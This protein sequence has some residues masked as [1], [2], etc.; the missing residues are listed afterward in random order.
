[1]FPNIWVNATLLATS[2][3]ATLGAVTKLFDIAD[4]GLS[5]PVK[6]SIAEIAVVRPVGEVTARV[7]N[8]FAHAF[9]A[10]F[11]AEHFTVKC[12]TR[13]AMASYVVTGLASL[14]WLVRPETR[15]QLSHAPAADVASVLLIAPLAVN[16]LPDYVSLVKTR[17][18][19][20]WLNEASSAKRW[21]AAMLLDVILSLAIALTSIAFWESQLIAERNCESF[22]AA[23]AVLGGACSQADFMTFWRRGF[24]ESLVSLVAALPMM[25]KLHPLSAPGFSAGIWLY[26]A[27]M[28]TLWLLLFATA[29]WVVRMGW[30]VEWA[31]RV[32]RKW[33]IIETRPLGG[34][35]LVASV[36]ITI[37]YALLAAAWII[38]SL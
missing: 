23:T 3:L 37:C 13:S 8:K 34:L 16:V 32:A 26:P 25:L 6:Q 28:G 33:T 18:I 15:A 5:D 35:A 24:S 31:R 7:A 1:M 19:I 17:R 27:F 12:F 30:M 4:K 10:V 14:L 36:L 9:D 2:W 38:R 29:N 11:G 20:G 22:V 21:L